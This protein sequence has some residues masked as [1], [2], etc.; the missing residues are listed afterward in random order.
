MAD[1][2]IQAR[3]AGTKLRRNRRAVDRRKLRLPR[4]TGVEAQAVEVQE[5]VDPVLAPP[6]W[7]PA[8]T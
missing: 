7:P 8:V 5:V 3:K 2:A 4:V 1:C 6:A